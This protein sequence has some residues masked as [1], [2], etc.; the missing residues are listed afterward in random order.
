MGEARRAERRE[1]GETEIDDGNRRDGIIVEGVKT[2]T[3]ETDRHERERR[4]G[5]GGLSY[6][7]MGTR[8]ELTLDLERQ[9]QRYRRQSTRKGVMGDIRTA[10]TMV[11][12]AERQGYG[13]K[14]SHGGESKSGHQRSCRYS[15]RGNTSSRKRSVR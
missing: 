2:K 12:R 13:N 4:T 6:N 9:E 1:R 7:P 14:I 5:K 8:A 3:R 15:R 11:W 10:Q